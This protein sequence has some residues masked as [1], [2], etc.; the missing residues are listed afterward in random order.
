MKPLNKQKVFTLI[1]L[2]ENNGRPS[3]I[4][5]YVHNGLKLEVEKKEGY[6]FT[7]EQMEE[8]IGEVI[9]SGCIMGI[10]YANDKSSQ[11][12]INFRNSKQELIKQ[13]LQC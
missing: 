9:E 3:I 13:L 1:P 6:F 5:K 4:V 10:Q 7:S 2:K 8:F 12:E 11:C